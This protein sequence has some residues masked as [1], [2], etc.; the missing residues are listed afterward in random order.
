M[1]KVTTV[2]ILLFFYAFL[3]KPSANAA[4][5]EIY[6]T[7]N[8]L[9]IL[10]N[11]QFSLNSILSPGS[12]K[13]VGVDLYIKFD[14]TAMQLDSIVPSSTSTFTFAVMPISCKGT[15]TSKPCIDNNSGE[16]SLSLAVPLGNTPLSAI[17]N[18]AVFNFSA[19][20]S[21]GNY[22]INYT[23][24]TQ[25]W[26]NGKNILQTRTLSSV[27]ITGSSIK[28][29]QPTNTPSQPE[30]V[31]NSIVPSAYPTNKK[32]VPS[33]KS[34]KSGSNKP[35]SEVSET[36]P[37]STNSLSVSVD[38][39]ADDA[40]QDGQ[41]IDINSNSIWLGVG[42]AKAMSYTGFRFRNI[43]LPKGAK[44]TSA[45]LEFYNDRSQ[46][47]SCRVL[48]YGVQNSVNTF[49]QSNLLSDQKA[50]SIKKLLDCSKKLNFFDNLLEFFGLLPSKSVDWSLNQWY[51]LGDIGTIIQEQ[52][53][54]GDWKNGN[55]LTIILKGR[56][57]IDH[58][59]YFSSYDNLS[60]KA[61]KLVINYQ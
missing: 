53:D 44:I 34:E 37:Q 9:S 10:P 28:V 36:V 24:D 23:S 60:S 8:V 50:Q 26:E 38:R 51:S 30:I 57:Q 59:V 35:T 42:D 49:S 20:S 27:T 11:S 45:Y 3:V 55:D 46:N 40:N 33:D 12:S 4:S 41:N 48:A 29:S 56:G 6:F 39:F 7:P 18:L 19:K 25:A 54:R 1:K 32:T 52:V 47:A 43:N 15:I 5:G 31:V 14:S 2:F 61:P 21:A 13:V 22:T 58:R 16:A 17:T